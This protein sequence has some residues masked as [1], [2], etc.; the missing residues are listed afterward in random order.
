M[1]KPRKKATLLTA[2]LVAG[3]LLGTVRVSPAATERGLHGGASSVEE[4]VSRFLDALAKKDAKALRGLRVERDEYIDLILRGNVPVGA[5]LR[6]WPA[7]VNEYWWSVLHTKSVYWEANLLAG[8]GGHH[9]RLKHVEFTKGTKEYATYTAYK[10][11]AV[12]VEE[13]DGTDK[14]IRTGSVAEVNGRYKFIS[15]IRD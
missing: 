14:D 8:L 2:L 1:N 5:P 3:A 6:H 15:Y 11:I 7:D 13:E 10:Q 4:L 12:T 9:Y